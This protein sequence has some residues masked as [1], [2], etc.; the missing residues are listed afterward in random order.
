[1]MPDRGRIV[2]HWHY[3]PA[4]ELGKSILPVVY[5]LVCE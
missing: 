1:M 3:P 2:M 4:A 5:G